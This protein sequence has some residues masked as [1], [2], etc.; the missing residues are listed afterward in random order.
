MPRSAQ[1]LKRSKQ[2][3]PYSKRVKYSSS[4]ASK[5]RSGALSTSR[6]A[7]GVENK[8]LDTSFTGPLALADTWENVS[9][10]VGLLNNIAQ[11]DGES[12]RDGRKAILTSVHGKVEVQTGG[13]NPLRIIAFI[14]HQTNGAATSIATVLDTAS[15]AND[16]LSF[17]NLQQTKRFTILCDET[18]SAL[19]YGGGSDYVFNFNKKLDLPVQYSGSTPSIADVVDNSIQVWAYQATSVA[20]TTFDAEF[21]VR[22]IG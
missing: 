3:G 15:S 16:L 4:R 7:L 17:R 21:R 20:G 11:G 19:Q 6:R 22:F 8:F 2:N 10:T 12:N 5:P 13:N 14:D 1:T 9:G 18:F